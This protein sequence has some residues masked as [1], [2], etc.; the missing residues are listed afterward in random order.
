MSIE[1]SPG[2]A[3]RIANAVYSVNKDDELSLELFLA[4]KL[5]ANKSSQKQLL[6]AAV[7]GRI[8]RAAEDAF[9]LSAIGGASHPN[10][11][12]LVQEPLSMF[13]KVKCKVVKKYCNKKL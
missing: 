7:G 1:L 4:D 11:L 13:M 12:F 9:G 5:F 10:D 8:F 6:K 3:A 2:E